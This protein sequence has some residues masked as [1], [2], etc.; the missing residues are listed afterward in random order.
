MPGFGPLDATV[1]VHQMVE[2]IISRV[3][4]EAKNFGE[5][6]STKVPHIA[7]FQQVPAAPSHGENSAG[8]NVLTDARSDQG[9]AGTLVAPKDDP[10]VSIASEQ[11]R[12]ALT[13][14]PAQEQKILRRTHGGALPH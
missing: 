12:D 2:Q 13:T 3:G 11:E 5:A 14:E 4:E 6:G 10:E 1:N 7:D 9:V 8:S